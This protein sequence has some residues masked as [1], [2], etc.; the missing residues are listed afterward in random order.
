[1][2]GENGS[3]CDRQNIFP[4]ISKALKLFITIPVTSCS[5]KRI[6]SKSNIV[7]TK[8]RST[9]GQDRLDGLLNMFVEQEQAYNVD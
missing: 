5:C 1:M 9:L 7:K 8:L 2:N 6:F 4:I 3:S